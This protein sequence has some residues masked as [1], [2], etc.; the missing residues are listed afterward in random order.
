MSILLALEVIN[1]SN[2]RKLMKL[3]FNLTNTCKNINLIAIPSIKAF[4]AYVGVTV[5][6]PSL[7]T[8]AVVNCRWPE[9]Q[10]L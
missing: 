5:S 3:I 9:K 7:L 1:Y 6:F 10:R 8:Q 2:L 4:F